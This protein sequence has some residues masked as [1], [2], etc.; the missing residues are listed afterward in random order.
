MIKL[1][2]TCAKDFLSLVN[3]Y[4][5]HRQALEELC[6]KGLDDDLKVEARLL[7]KTGFFTSLSKFFTI[8]AE[9]IAGTLTNSFHN[10]LIK[11]TNDINDEIAEKYGIKIN[12]DE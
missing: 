10:W 8:F 6:Q 5:S 9:D 3:R 12:E 2:E 4:L 1:N 7:S 11:K